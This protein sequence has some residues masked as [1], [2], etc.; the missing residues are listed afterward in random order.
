[1]LECLLQAWAKHRGNYNEKY[2]PDDKKLKGNFRCA[3]TK[4]DD[5]EEMKNYSKT[6]Q[7]MGNY[8]VFKLLTPQEVTG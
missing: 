1:M 8:K 4:S 6:N 7:Q 3:L 5:F 2:P